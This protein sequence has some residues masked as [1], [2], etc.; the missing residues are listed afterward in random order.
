MIRAF[1]HQ[2]RDESAGEIACHGGYGKI[3]LKS[4]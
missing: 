1:V 2:E 3:H 4:F